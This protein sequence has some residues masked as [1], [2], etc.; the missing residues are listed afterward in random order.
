M[1]ATSAS[2]LYKDRMPSIAYLLK[3]V[4][5]EHN[6]VLRVRTFLSFLRP[7]FYFLLVYYIYIH[8]YYY[9]LFS[10]RY[11]PILP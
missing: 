1:A 6:M 3:I 5:T 7:R 2:D 8:M 4:R 9:S 10:D 11:K